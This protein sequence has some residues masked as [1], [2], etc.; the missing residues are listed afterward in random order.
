MIKIDSKE[1]VKKIRTNALI[2]IAFAC[3]IAYSIACFTEWT[4]N[5]KLWHPVTRGLFG[6]AVFAALAWSVTHAAGMINA[7]RRQMEEWKRQIDE[8]MKQEE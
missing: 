5:F 3:S 7:H 4:A 2:S 1:V 6:L 8:Q